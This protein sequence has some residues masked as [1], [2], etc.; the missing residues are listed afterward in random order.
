MIAPPIYNAVR[1][2]AEI[3]DVREIEPRL[4]E[5]RLFVVAAPDFCSADFPVGKV[6]PLGRHR[7][8]VLLFSP[9]PTGCAACR[10]CPLQRLAVRWHVSR[11][12][13][14]SAIYRPQN[15]TRPVVMASTMN[16][17]V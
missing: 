2:K 7:P 16:F 13:R 4:R 8:F 5:F 10:L 6:A 17:R 9:S 14:W 1:P 11:P 12:G 15:D 3:E